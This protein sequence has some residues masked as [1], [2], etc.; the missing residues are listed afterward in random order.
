M[1]YKVQKAIAKTL[2][3]IVTLAA[4]VACSV[5]LYMFICLYLEY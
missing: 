1:W 3:A 5:A 2:E 4:V